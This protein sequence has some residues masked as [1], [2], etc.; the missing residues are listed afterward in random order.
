MENTS[1]PQS[2]SLASP[3]RKLGGFDKA[4][5]ALGLVGALFMGYLAKLHYKP[6]DSTI[7]NFGEGFSCEVVNQSLYSDVSGIPLSVLGLV[8][9]LTVALLAWKKFL[10]NPYRIIQLFTIFSLVFGASLTYIELRVIGSICVFCEG[11]KL[12]MLGI[13]GLTTVHEKR[14]K[15]LAPWS[16]YVGAIAA[17]LVFSAVVR[18]MQENF[19]TLF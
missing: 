5:I 16:Y 6:S 15:N 4:V 19:I 9:F 14:A 1:I 11:S 3:F 2:Q 17:G 12:L 10:R 8:Y 7:C 18:Y 13:L